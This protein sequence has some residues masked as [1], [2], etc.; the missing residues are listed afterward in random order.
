MSMYKVKILGLFFSLALTVML[1]ACGMFATGGGDPNDVSCDNVLKKHAEGLLW[2]LSLTCRYQEKCEAEISPFV[3]LG[4][5]VN[6]EECYDHYE[7]KFDDGKTKKTVKMNTTVPVTVDDDDHVRFS[8]FDSEKVEKTY[9]IDLSEIIHSYT[10]KDD[11]VEI[12]MPENNFTMSIHCPYCSN[13]DY[14]DLCQ[15]TYACHYRGN[16]DFTS[17]RVGTD[18]SWGTSYT[19]RYYLGEQSSMK[20]DSIKVIGEI[21]I[22]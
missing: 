10:V 15:G 3:T 8:L 13:S 18:S 14:S 19:L 7:Y 5:P 9:D 21:Y 17:V 16:S 6:P 12:K 4:K 11:S 2:N 1:V 20:G 22:R